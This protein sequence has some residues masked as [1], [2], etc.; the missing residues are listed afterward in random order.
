M[1]R[2][3]S[4]EEILSWSFGEV[5]KPETINYRTQR[6]E[7]DGLFDERIF[8]P[9]KDYECYCGKYRRIRYK[10]IVCERCGVEVTRSIVRRE[11]MG[12]ITLASPVAHIWY[13]KGVPS[14]LGLLLDL[15]IND[16][17]KIIY[18]AG[19]IIVKVDEEL[20]KEALVAL[21]KEFKIRLKQAG[22]KKEK[23]EL[24]SAFSS[25]AS[26]LEA[27]ALNK[28]LSEEEYRQ[29]SLKY[30][31]VFEAQAGPEALYEICKKINLDDLEKK[32]EEAYRSSPLQT[33][34]KAIKQL[35]LVKAMKRSGIRPEWMFLT[36]IPVIPPALR[37]MVQLDGGRHATSD[38]N[39]LYRRV[40]NRNNRLKR[41]LELN[42]PEVI[43][44]NEKRMLQEAVD[45]LIDNS[46][47]RGRGG[48][49]VSKSQ[50]R[51]LK[52]LADTLRGK[53]GRFRQNLLG[54]RVDYSGRSVI[55][56]GPELKMHQC[57]LPK[58]MALELFRPFV[59]SK[60]IERE[61]AYNVR[62][63]NRLI[64]EKTDEVWAILEEVISD[65]YVLL[66]RAPTLHRLSIQAFQP[67]LIEGNAIQLHPLVCTAF[68]ADFDGDQ[69]AVHLPLSKEAQKEAR[70]L[71][72]ST[73]NLLIP[74][75]GE[76]IVNPSQD[77]VLG[78]FWMT[79]VK[80]GAKGTGVY[81]SSPNEAI[82]SYDFGFTELQAMIKVL[83]TK[84]PKYK[85][86][87]ENIIETTVGRLLFNS[88]LPDDFSYINKEFNKKELS[89]L[90]SDLIERYGAEAVPPILDK[91][92][93]FGFYYAT[94]SGL[95]WGM[96]D[97]LISPKK[98]EIIKEAAETEKTIY[99]NFEKGLLTEEERYEQ[100]V[101]LWQEVKK[102]VDQS[103]PSVLDQF[104]P[105]FTIVV[106]AARG[107]WSQ[108][109][110]IAGMKGLVRNPAGKIIDFPIVS[111]YKEGLNVLEYFISTHGARKG[112]ADTALKTAK[113]GYLTRRLV[114]VAQDVIIS[115]KDCKTK[116]GLRIKRS[117]VE[118]YG[119]SIAEKVEGRVL[120]KD[121]VVAKDRILKKGF[122]IREVEAKMI[123]DSGVEEVWIRSALTCDSAWGVC[124]LCYGYDLG[125]NKL[126]EPGLP[127]GIVAAQA[128]GEPGTQLTMRTFHTG[129]I[130]GRGGDITLGLPRVEELFE[131]RTP[132]EPAV[133]SE[134]TGT[135][136]EI[137][138]RE[139]T[140]I[141][142]IL[143][144]SLP[145][146]K[147][148]SR[149]LE[150]KI[151]FGKKILVELNH[152]VRAG[153][154]LSD[155]AIDIKE[156]FKVA[157]EEAAK[158]YVLREASRVYKLQ[159]VSVN[160]KHFE[161]IIRQMFSRFIVKDP[162]DTI[163]SPGQ[164]VERTAFL[165]ENNRVKNT[166]GKEATFI[167]TVKGISKVALSTSSFLSA[168]SFQDTARV[169]IKAS[170]EGS[171]DKLRGLK[172][173][174]I[175]GRL[176]PAG[177]A[178]NFRKISR[179]KDKKP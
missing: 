28:V 120:A 58:H 78:C 99:K 134:A 52:S 110:Q 137:K 145:K 33:Q 66:N 47:K 111:S 64:D 84:S 152:K 10:G 43:I 65:R 117:E 144:D 139:E 50:R 27:I 32:F 171:K 81:F 41:L 173:N 88:V 148:A 49:V 121:L 36:V 90:V 106:S 164:V 142:R 63:A 44:R 20:K 2:L 167:K 169:L 98:R 130:A 14:R 141:V 39:D 35:E 53:Q 94:K 13:V 68:N 136:I 86:F 154:P 103:V 73:K 57:G 162:G 70:E 118:S 55:V 125:H 74:R 93:A 95:S 1:L 16:L 34:R 150:Y 91:I 72:A 37:P 104:G 101:S 6:P 123:E 165:E 129:G 12:H 100:L 126:V 102:E 157:G 149:A 22:T 29:L 105:V 175:I 124:S 75:N 60:I 177:T 18:F 116:A 77:M 163:F 159:G 161:I 166:K 151:P 127:V 122:L 138:E 107:S 147:S 179:Q 176:I 133:I 119:E 114:D 140:K 56:V 158:R 156:L 24:K 3:A 172:E 96:E 82:T 42:A 174:V 5:T 113:A 89:K 168:A 155:G 97:I 11:R 61:L 85:V 25:A 146:S 178:F 143:P 87:K 51:P 54:K 69:M 62:G 45:S 23:A 19:Y 71:I 17:E 48:A 31:E 26:A 59:I 21:K 108:I 83:V 92:K 8:G 112:A 128:I 46:I 131:A 40:L 115:E 76:P 153:D 132:A 109:N 67:V 80:E 4:P 7:R 79:R 30:G 170:L 135:V 15:S 38:V 160:D 9:Q